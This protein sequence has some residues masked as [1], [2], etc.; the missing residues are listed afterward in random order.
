MSAWHCLSVILISNQI[1]CVN[2]FS[3]FSGT[4]YR[5]GN[6]RLHSHPISSFDANRQIFCNVEL[7][8]E[9]I[10]AVGFDMDF[11]LAQVS[12]NFTATT[13][14]LNFIAVCM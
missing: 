8:G 4:T 2:S 6:F 11:T 13:N 1:V 10:E 14:S 3:R 5:T 12:P 7:N 9:S